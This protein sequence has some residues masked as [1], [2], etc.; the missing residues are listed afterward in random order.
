MLLCRGKVMPSSVK[1]GKVKIEFHSDISYTAMVMLS[2]VKL[3]FVA[4][5]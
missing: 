2:S 3:C 1:Y 5:K 4:V